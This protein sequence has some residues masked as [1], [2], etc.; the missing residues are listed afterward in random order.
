M[1]VLTWAPETLPPILSS[2]LYPGV[3]YPV[4]SYIMVSLV[5]PPTVFQ[6]DGML[7]IRIPFLSLASRLRRNHN[8]I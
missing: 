4:L 8:G 7:T 1:L 2:I 5:H 3:S 6:S